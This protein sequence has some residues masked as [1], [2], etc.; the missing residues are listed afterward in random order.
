VHPKPPSLSAFLIPAP[1]AVALD[2]VW[3]I[4]MPPEAGVGVQQLAIEPDIVAERQQR[5]ATRATNSGPVELQLMSPEAVAGV[6]P[7][8]QLTVRAGDGAVYLPH[9][10]R[11]E[12]MRFEPALYA[13]ALREI[14]REAFINGSVW[15]AFIAFASDAEAPAT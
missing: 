4:A 10:I 15:C 7:A 3:Q 5:Y 2:G 6:S 9:Q 14:P 11:L 12:E 1:D 13:T 8:V